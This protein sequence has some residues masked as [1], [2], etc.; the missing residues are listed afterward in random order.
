MFNR[1]ILQLAVPM[2]LSNLTAPLLGLVDTAVL[3]HLSHP[4]Y[5]AGAGVGVAIIN[6]L[7]WSFGFLRMSTTG[8][9]AQKNSSNEQQI[10]YD[11]I[12]RGLIL[13]FFIGLILL[14]LRPL[15]IPLALSVM[16]PSMVIAEQARIFLNIL[17]F[18]LPFALCNFV[19]MGA[20]IGFSRPRQVLLMTICMNI[21]GIVLDLLL[22]NFFHF[23]TAGVA[24]S[25]ISSYVCGTFIGLYLLRKEVLFIVFKQSFASLF[26][27][28]SMMIFFVLNRDIFI[29]TICLIAV[30]TYFTRAG[31]QYGQITLTSNLVL[32]NFFTFFAF[33]ADGFAN[34]AEVLVGECVGNQNKISLIKVVKTCAWWSL[35]ISVLFSLI[36]ALSHTFI[37]RALTSLISVREMATQVS[38]WV[39]VLPVL[40]VWGFLFD[41]IYIGATMTREMR[42]T[43]VF[44]LA[45][46]ALLRFISLPLL[47]DGLW[48]SFL[49]YLLARGVSMWLV[50]VRKLSMPQA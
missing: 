50:F 3:G 9:V 41:G 5:L 38:I 27:K 35:G 42:N 26:N 33:A 2:I 18:G 36:Y 8:V 13:A 21:I 17:F 15:L 29:R 43:M 14:F 30:F 44:S 45:C 32:M 22:V 49:G 4:R 6:M 47:N 34:A 7:L 25:T 11:H 12:F 19:L 23:K 48:I 16:S 20:L 37:I 40:A 39:V 24:V 28:K 1:R 31:A 10:A 46:F